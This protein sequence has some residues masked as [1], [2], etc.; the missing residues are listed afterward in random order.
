MSGSASA[1]YV[2][3]TPD[4]PFALDV[5]RSAVAHAVVPLEIEELDGVAFQGHLAQ[6]VV[7]NVSLFEIVATPHVVRR[8]PELISDDDNR[9]Y[10]L[11]LQLAGPAVLEQDGRSV[12]LRPGD[13]AIYDTHRPYTLTFPERNQ[14]MVIMFPH[15]LVDLPRDEVARVTATRFPSETGLGRVINP[16]FVEL[17]RNMDQLAGS[18]ASRLVHSALDLLVTMLSQEL[19]RRQGPAT[20]PARSLAREVREY[21]LEHLGEHDLTPSSIARAH[22]ISTRHLYTIFSAEGQTVSVWIRSRRL[23]HIRRDLADPL[24]AD[25]PVSWV[26]GRWGLHDAAHFS[27]LFK[28][29][30]GESPTAYRERLLG[31]RARQAG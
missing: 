19:H 15:E 12:E 31:D 25:R 20:N 30:F 8:T 17:G 6:T 28:A 1:S 9:F 21:I 29:E 27:R 10:K 5:W 14:A 2:I 7:G 4:A 18:H 24:F 13:L 11:S 3:D 22:Y 16:F 23:E 26:A